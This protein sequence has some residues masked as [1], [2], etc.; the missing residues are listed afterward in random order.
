MQVKKF[1]GLF[2]RVITISDATGLH[3]PNS[4]YRLKNCHAATAAASLILYCVSAPNRF[5]LM[6]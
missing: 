4:S 5:G 2:V 3:F 6:L 1:I